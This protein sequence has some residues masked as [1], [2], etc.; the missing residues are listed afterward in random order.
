VRAVEDALRS[1][2][3]DEILIV[4]CASE[5]GASR[6]HCGSS[7]CPSLDSEGQCLRVPKLCSRRKINP[8]C[9]QNGVP[10]THTD[11]AEKPKG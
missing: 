8:I 5:D 1:F 2:P 3:A 11:D 9:R 7:T 6:H 4:G 10:T